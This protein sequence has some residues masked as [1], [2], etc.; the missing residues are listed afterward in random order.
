MFDGGLRL[1]TR[2][3]ML[4]DAESAAIVLIRGTDVVEAFIEWSKARGYHTP[5]K[6][7]VDGTETEPNP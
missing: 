5:G 7:I 1:K 2:D 3:A 4:L 6:G